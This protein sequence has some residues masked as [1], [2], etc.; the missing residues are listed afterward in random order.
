MYI[1]QY[2]EREVQR[3]I[4]L[5]FSSAA[6]RRE[7][8]AP[9][10]EDDLSHDAACHAIRTVVLLTMV[11]QTSVLKDNNGMVGEE[12]EVEDGERIEGGSKGK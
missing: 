11:A 3:C 12:G 6:E 4:T 5:P 2:R 9:G 1:C 8:L 10:A 7:A